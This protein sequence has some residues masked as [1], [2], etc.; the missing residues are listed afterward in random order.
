MTQIFVSHAEQD[1]G[2][3]EAMRQGLEGKGYSTWR[4][5]KTL[6]LH[7]I[8]Y[9]RT[10]DNVILG[11]AAVVLVWSS[12]AAQSEW[13]ERHLLFTSRLKKL[14]VPVVLDGTS[15]PNTLIAVQALAG[16]VPCADV[17]AHLPADFPPPHSTDPL[18]LLAEQAA[19]TLIRVRKEAIDAA[20]AMLQQGE[21]REAVLVVLEYLA[22]NDLM[23]GVRDK[24]Q[25]VLDKEQRKAVPAPPAG[26]S[27]HSFGVR[28]PNG[29]VTY[30]ERHHVCSAQ[31]NI[32]R[33]RQ[34]RARRELDELD[35]KCETCG[36]TMPARVDCEGYR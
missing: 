23:M 13:V 2:C 28:C 26:Q 3:A 24:A 33:R 21:Q 6:E 29:H 36:V 7:S 30:F 34:E 25:E 5:P 9:P 11:S 20:A 19:H 35:L 32:V 17:V 31:A 27:R 14:I 16:S 10:I 18:V 12:S 15:L 22:R 4:E 1:A 8:L